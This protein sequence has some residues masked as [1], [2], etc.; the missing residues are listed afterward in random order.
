M[1]LADLLTPLIPS[2]KRSLRARR[3]SPKTIKAYGDAGRMFT[4]HQW[5]GC[6][7]LDPQEVTRGDVQDFITAQLDQWSAST[8]ATRYRCLQQFWK[9]IV[10]DGEVDV[11]P[12]AKMG[13]PTIPEAPVPVL[14]DDE[15][16]RSF[17]ICDGRGFEQRRDAAIDQYLRE[18]MRHR[19]PPRPDC[20]SDPGATRPR[21]PRRHQ[22]PRTRRR[23][24]R[25]RRPSQ[26]PRP[27]PR[28]QRPPRRPP[29]PHLRNRS[30]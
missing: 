29:R 6:R 25:P 2:F 3:R 7:I 9:W 20:G 16:C 12:M 23:R 28:R 19:E 10:D 27:R 4:E 5:A 15:L 24:S 22:R 17:A 8:A 30:P 11:S 14:D 18:R 1:G 21:R 26:R 13:P